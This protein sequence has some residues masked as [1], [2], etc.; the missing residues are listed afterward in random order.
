VNQVIGSAG[1]PWP[2]VRQRRRPADPAGRRGEGV[3]VDAST[4]A[5][6]VHLGVHLARLVAMMLSVELARLVAMMLSVELARLVAVVFGVEMVGMGHVGVVGRFFVM[7]GF[8]RLGGVVVMLGRVLVVFRRFAVMFDLFLVGH[9]L[10]LVE[11]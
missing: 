8:V 1:R 5:S 7:A 2:A 9:D 3:A 10:I 6:G 11:G 4:V